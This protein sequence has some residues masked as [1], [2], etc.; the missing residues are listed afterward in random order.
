VSVSASY[1][2]LY[3]SSWLL[4]PSKGNLET[5]SEI[6]GRKSVLELCRL[7]NVCWNNEPE[8]KLTAASPV[9]RLHFF[10]A[11]GIDN[12]T[13]AGSC[14]R[15]IYLGSVFSHNTIAHCSS[16]FCVSIH[17]ARPNVMSP[18]LLGSFVALC[19]SL[20]KQLF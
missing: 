12:R 15:S 1:N 20:T 5:R 10:L 8:G 3:Q 6:S 13:H 2:A 18:S 7:G 11:N 16:I 4:T 9:V 17:F 14:W 19:I